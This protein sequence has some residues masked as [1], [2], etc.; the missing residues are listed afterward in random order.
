VA[1]AASAALIL[2]PPS[3]AGQDQ[4]ARRIQ[5]TQV[6][7]RVVAHDA[8]IIGSAVGGARVTIWDARTGA[9]LAQG[10]Q[11]GGT[12]DTQ[13][14]MVDAR[15]RGGTVFDTDRAGGFL[16]EL[17]LAAPT[18][19]RIE[20]EGP[21][22]AAQA[23][24]RSSRTLLMVPGNHILGE[25]VI[26]ELHGFTVELLE[27]DSDLSRTAGSELAVR[28]RVTMLCGCPTEPGGMWDSS[29][30]TIEV[31]IARGEEVL[32]RAALHFSGETSIYE[33]RI[34]VP[35]DENLTGLSLQVIAMDP[36]A[37]NFGMVERPFEGIGRGQSSD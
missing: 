23:I 20:A 28:A 5:P 32:D 17:D 30:Y 18:Q 22:G 9:L 8:K 12:G 34:R 36:Q 29:G 1:L 10:V 31:R 7:V 2:V 4:A 26:L 35:A 15:T 13:H 25:G 14:I 37:G 33:G 24:Q 19:V 16:A 21:L 3:L 6:M 27:P 11:E